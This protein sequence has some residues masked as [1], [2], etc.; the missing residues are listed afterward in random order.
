MAHETYAFAL[1][2]QGTLKLAQA[3]LASQMPILKNET[4]NELNQMMRNYDEN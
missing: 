2:E 3:L 1:I 4:S